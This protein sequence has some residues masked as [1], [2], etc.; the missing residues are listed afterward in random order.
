MKEAI[1]EFETAT[2]LA[3]GLS[4]IVGHL[5]Y[6]YAQAGERPKALATLKA[7]E[8][9]ARHEPVPPVALAYAYLGLGDHDKT[10]AALQR[11]VEKHDVFIARFGLASE[12]PFAVL[13]DDPR[14]TAL[15]ERVGLTVPRPT[16]RP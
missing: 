13:R 2:R 3:P 12:P 14:F 5:V 16:A 8:D 9:R 1:T 4:Y 11:A 15:M 10:I 7:L 6:A